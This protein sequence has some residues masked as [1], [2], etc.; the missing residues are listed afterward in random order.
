VFGNL[1]ATTAIARRGTANQKESTQTLRKKQLPFQLYFPSS[2]IMPR[3]EPH[4]QK[5]GASQKHYRQNDA[6]QA[7]RVLPEG[8]DLDVKNKKGETPLFVSCAGSDTQ[9]IRVLLQQGADPDIPNKDEETPL[10]RACERGS[11]EAVRLL[12]RH[13][14]EVDIPNKYGETPLMRAAAHPHPEMAE[15]L[16]RAGA[17]PNL[18]DMN[19]RTPFMTACFH[20]PAETIKLFL[21]K[22]ANPNVKDSHEF[23]P[24]WV[25]CTASNTAVVK[26]L[27]QQG[28]KASHLHEP[29]QT[30]TR[31]E[32]IRQMIQ[33]AS[34]IRNVRSAAKSSFRQQQQT[35]QNH[36]K[37]K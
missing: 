8:A 26:M 24:L 33:E 34:R 9:T 23:T 4:Q 3:T 15:M 16:L 10:F 28:A 5:W 21:Q 20:F 35:K 19:G 22:G 1:E 17:N 14:A 32:Q 11:V 36:R 31:N 12:L 37:P 2:K 25:A 18:K 13:H 7:K 30:L 27:L 29:I 6:K